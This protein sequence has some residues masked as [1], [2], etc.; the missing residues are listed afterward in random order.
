[1]FN[2]L[3]GIK[4]KALQMNHRL[5]SNSTLCNNT[6]T[7]GW[8]LVCF[9]CVC[10]VSRYYHLLKEGF[11]VVWTKSNGDGVDKL[12]EVH[13]KLFCV[14]T[15]LSMLKLFETFLESA[16]QLL[17]QLYILLGHNEVS[18]MQCK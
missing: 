5:C 9:H 16:P 13:K 14:A 11:Q 18:V 4:V 15:D 17:L 10:L 3:Y 12:R 6:C 1:M 7:A 2:L 8:Q